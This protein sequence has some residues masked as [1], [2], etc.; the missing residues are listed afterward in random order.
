MVAIYVIAVLL[1]I[2]WAKPVYPVTT[3]VITT[4]GRH[5]VSRGGNFI[6]IY[7]QGDKLNYRI[8]RRYRN[9]SIVRSPA[10]AEIVK[11]SPW[12][13]FVE[14]SNRIWIFNGERMLLTLEMFRPSSMAGGFKREEL[15]ISIKGPKLV[16][17]APKGVRDR[18]P[19]AFKDRFTAGGRWETAV[20]DRRSG[21]PGPSSAGYAQRKEMSQLRAVLWC[22]W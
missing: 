14:T 6:E 2:K 22:S 16:E 20:I 3:G 17:E 7:E 8:G 19:Q 18:L 9:E 1:A 13:A 21:V 10:Q 12:F 4:L 11:G 15:E 5:Y